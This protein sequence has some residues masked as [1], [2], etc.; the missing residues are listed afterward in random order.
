MRLLRSTWKGRFLDGNH[1][2]KTPVKCAAS[3]FR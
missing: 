2:D 3:G 1:L